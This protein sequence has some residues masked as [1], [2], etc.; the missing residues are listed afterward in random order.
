[1]NSLEQGPMCVCYYSAWTIYVDD[2]AIVE[3]EMHVC[4]K[5]LT[6]F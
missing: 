5:A 4:R 3:F 1:M 2:F 6:I